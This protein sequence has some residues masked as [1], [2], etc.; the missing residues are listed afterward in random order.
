FTQDIID[1]LGSRIYELALPIPKD[2]SVQ[3]QVTNM[4]KRAIDERI[5]AR[6]LTRKACLEVV[7]IT[8]SAPNHNH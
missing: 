5:E 4:V 3:E 6:E 8:S 2:K 7:G 1:S